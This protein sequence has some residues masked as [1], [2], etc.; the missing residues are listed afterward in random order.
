MIWASALFAAALSSADIPAPDAVGG[1]LNETNAAQRLGACTYRHLKFYELS[2]ERPDDVA[3]ASMND[4]LVADKLFSQ[5]EISLV[6]ER[7]IQAVI[8]IRA[9][10]AANKTS[11]A[12]PRNH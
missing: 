12:T 5:A 11:S 8:E 3:R 6:H 9:A 4:C 2:G 10:R 1:Y 7:A